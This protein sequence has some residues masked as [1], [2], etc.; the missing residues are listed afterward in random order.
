[1]SRTAPD[2]AV[3]VLVLLCLKIAI[4]LL[5]LFLLALPCLLGQP[6]GLMK[7]TDFLLVLSHTWRSASH[8]GFCEAI[9][10]PLSISTISTIGVVNLSSTLGLRKLGE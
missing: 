4:Y 8:G 6:V 9:S 7:Q 3:S 5:G 10:P 2:T 1:M